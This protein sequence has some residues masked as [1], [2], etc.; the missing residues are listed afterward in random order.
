M[1]IGGC[2]IAI[3]L[4][5]SCSRVRRNTGRAYMPDMYYSRAYETYASTEALQNEKYSGVYNAV[6]PFPVNNRELILQIA[7][8]RKKFFIP[9]H[10]PV[11]VLRTMLG[12][13]SVEILKSTTVSSAKLQREGFQFKFPKIQDAIKD[14]ET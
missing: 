12:E 8:Q 2:I 4:V 13:M 14:L 6:S 11:F 7:R 1:F 9:V 10:V 5:E 3:M